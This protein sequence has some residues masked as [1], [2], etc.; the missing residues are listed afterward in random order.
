MLAG[1]RVKL[2]GTDEA[3]PEVR[4]LTAGALSVD[5]VDGGL[6]TIRWRGVEVLRAVA[7]VVRDRDW[8]TY[9]PTIENLAVDQ[10]DDGFSLSY[11]AICPAPDGATLRF[12]AVITGD[13]T[14]RLRFT[15]EA[16]PDADFETNRCG[17]CVLHPITDLAG[18]P[19]TVTH[20]D[21]STEHAAFPDLIAPWQPFKDM[22]A[23]AHQV[24]PGTTA[25][26]TMEGDSFEMEDQ[27]AWSDA[28]YKTYVR[29]LA[30]P[31]PYR[32]PAGETNRQSVVLTIDEADGHAASAT[33]ALQ[34]SARNEVA[35][36]LRNPASKPRP[37]PASAYPSHRKRLKPHL[38]RSTGCATSPPGIFCSPSIPR[39]VTGAL[40]WRRSPISPKR[41]RRPG[42][43]WKLPCRGSQRPQRNWR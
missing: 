11:R 15:V 33:P 32:L 16:V 39:Q 8:G 2:Y 24:L 1:D 6:R 9:A 41:C 5:L 35:V 22:R 31:W 42:S 7:Y 19:A 30:L 37:C 21:G 25:L 43:R 14:G 10:R 4:T 26:C 34:T 36:A 29:P 38:P 28:S 3:P 17:F 13:A 40:S 12:S 20:T 18:G 23:I 27:R